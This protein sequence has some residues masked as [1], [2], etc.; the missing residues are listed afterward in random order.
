MKV[1]CC[2]C[3]HC[4]MIDFDTFWCELKG[5]RI[6]MTHYGTFKYERKCDDFKDKAVK[7]NGFRIK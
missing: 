4:C 2:D 7:D 3:E 6:T 5:S 1:K